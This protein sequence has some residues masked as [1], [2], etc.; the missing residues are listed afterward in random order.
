[1]FL[2]KIKMRLKWDF[3]GYENFHLNVTEQRLCR[4]CDFF[5]EIKMRLKWD[6]YGYWKFHLTVIEQRLCGNGDFLGEIKMIILWLLKFSFKFCWKKAASELRFFGETEMIFLWLLKISFKISPKRG[7]VGNRTTPV[8][9]HTLTAYTVR[10]ERERERERG[11]ERGT[12][13]VNAHMYLRTLCFKCELCQL[14]SKP[15]ALIKHIAQAFITGGTEVRFV[16]ANPWW[17]LS[18]RHCFSSS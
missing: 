1:M 4:N 5:D 9:V 16:R 10:R 14:P 18:V 2:A 17:D 13:T 3:Y 11:R 6:F 15:A 12:E 7:Y 8:A